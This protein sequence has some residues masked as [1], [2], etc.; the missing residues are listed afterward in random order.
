MMSEP[1]TWGGATA[2]PENFTVTPANLCDCVISGFSLNSL[3]PIKRF[4]IY[5]MILYVYIKD[6]IIYIYAPQTNLM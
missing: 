6:T 2:S 3:I 4:V 1:P 5:D